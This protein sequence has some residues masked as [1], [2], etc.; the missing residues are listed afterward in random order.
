M[1][2]QIIGYS[3]SGKSTLARKLGEYYNIPVLH[4]DSVHFKNN[5]EERTDEEFNEIVSRFIEE[6]ESWIIDGNYSRI[7]P[8]RFEISDQLIFLNY[9]RFV[10]YFSAR[11][12]Y[13]KYKNKTRPDMAEGCNEKFDSEFK[14]WLLYKGRTKKRQRKYMK[15]INNHKNG[16]VFKNR[17]QTNKYLNSLIK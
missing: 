4:L 15:L 2:I 7:A 11:K 16:I 13:K 10:C 9:N 6:N 12:R 5:W 3:G 1:K 8:I 17:K 14:K